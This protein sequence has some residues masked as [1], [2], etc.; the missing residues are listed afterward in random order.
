MITCRHGPQRPRSAGSNRESGKTTTGLL[1]QKHFSGSIVARDEQFSPNSYYQE[2]CVNTS[3][4]RTV[5]DCSYLTNDSDDGDDDTLTRTSKPKH[6]P[7][8]SIDDDISIEIEPSQLNIRSRSSDHS[9][10]GSSSFKRRTGIRARS[11]SRSRKERS[12]KMDIC[13][14]L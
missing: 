3:H 4:V 9:N 12:N 2:Y 6:Q 13:A 14:E 10:T 1:L 7:I 5:S 11:A 8:R